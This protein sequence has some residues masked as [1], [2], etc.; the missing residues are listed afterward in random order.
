MK[1]STDNLWI[2]KNHFNK[3]DIVLD[4]AARTGSGLKTWEEEIVGELLSPP[5]K[6]L[7]IGCGTGREAFA[8]CDLGFDV[9][10]I[11]LSEKLISLAASEGIKRGKKITFEICT[12]DLSYKY[13]D[14]T[15]DYIVMW[16]QAFG[17]VYGQDNQIKLI[18]ECKRLLKSNGIFCFSGHSLNYVKHAHN[19]YTSG[20][21]FFAI[22]DTDCYWELFT[23]DDFQ[24]LCDRAGLGVLKRCNSMELG[25]T[26]TEQV[27][28]CVATKE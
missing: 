3:A 27:L 17:N 5:G 7:D 10:G 9:T 12:T 6:I 8:L 22:A 13:P 1:D 2:V 4:M 26:E 14:E 16:S 24:Y 23:L 25:S 19:E 15:F 21:K 18:T 11:D 20:N 28:V